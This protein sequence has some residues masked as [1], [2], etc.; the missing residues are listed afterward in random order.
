M[1]D[2]SRGSTCRRVVRACLCL[3][4]GVEGVHGMRRLARAMCAGAALVCWLGGFV[5]AFWPAPPIDDLATSVS[6]FA[7]SRYG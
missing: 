2:T 3:N 1:T 7:E 4:A 5:E 6:S